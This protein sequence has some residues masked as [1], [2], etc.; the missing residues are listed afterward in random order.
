MDFNIEAAD[1]IEDE[2]APEYLDT[3]AP[4]EVPK[5]V[6]ENAK[7]EQLE[8]SSANED[9]VPSVVINGS[10]TSTSPL[11]VKKKRPYNRRS[12]PKSEGPLVKLLKLSPNTLT[13]HMNGEMNPPS[14]PA[15]PHHEVEPSETQLPVEEPVTTPVPLA[16]PK[17]RTVNGPNLLRN[18]QVKKKVVVNSKTIYRKPNKASETLNRTSI[19]GVKP[20]G[21]PAEDSGLVE[22]VKCFSIVSISS[23]REHLAVCDSIIPAATEE[24]DIGI[25]L[26]SHMLAL[27]F[28]LKICSSIPIIVP[29]P[30]ESLPITTPVGLPLTLPSPISLS[31]SYG[32]RA[33]SIRSVQSTYGPDACGLCGARGLSDGLSRYLHAHLH[34]QRHACLVC[35]SMH[36]KVSALVK[37]LQAVHGKEDR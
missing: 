4:V 15:S 23:A 33:S 36:A 12:I 34:H 10:P 16:V 17:K 37:H 7:I 22:C 21:F 26:L 6:S 28:K 2:P 31:K 35:G 13:K 29:S 32:T 18:K 8:A 27:S 9:E 30:A 14:V 5:T 11:I 1:E 19:A 3:L 24:N 20:L 25:Q